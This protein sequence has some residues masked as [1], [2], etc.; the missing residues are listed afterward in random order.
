MAEFT[1][2]VGKK[3][4]M[5]DYILDGGILV[6]A[7]GRIDNILNKEDAEEIIVTKPPNVSVRNNVHQTRKFVVDCTF[8]V[9]YRCWK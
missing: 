9:D 6:G 1:L 2:F 3:I 7:N 4:V 5:E 8:V